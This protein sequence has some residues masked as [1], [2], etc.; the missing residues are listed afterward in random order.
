MQK[1]LIIGT[2][3]LRNYGCEAIVQGTYAILKHTLADAKVYVASDDKQY[4]AS[5]LPH[6]IR[7]V[8]YKQRFTLYRLWKGLLRRFFHYGTGSPVRMDVHVGKRF[9][10]V[11]SCGGDNYCEAPD[12]SLYNILLDL[13]A[14][15]EN[16]VKAHRKFV[17]WGASVGPFKKDNELSV[18]DNLQQSNLICVREKLSYDYLRPLG[19]GSKLNLTA[20]PAFLMEPDS[21]VKIEKNDGVQYI[22]L[23]ISRLSIGHAIKKAKEQE[24]F[25]NK[26]FNQL[27]A[28]LNRHPDW[29]FVCLPHVVIDNDAN[30]NDYVFMQKYFSATKHKSR[31]S[32]L[33]PDLGARK[34]K[35]CVCQMDLLVAARM[36]C[37]VAGI[38][39]STPTL[40]V[41]YSNKGRGMAEYAYGHHNYDMP[42]EGLVTDEFEKLVANMLAKKEQIR[43]GLENQQARFRNDALKAGELLRT[44][45]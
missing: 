28:I 30:Q 44:I 39:T 1:I 10:V 9:D 21:S 31:V 11:L 20:D 37:C 34:T 7:L 2:G 33:P 32:I 8:S 22:G 16:A 45:V 5:V 13:M 25:I 3:S 26:L 12:G 36:H 23:N 40:F 38:T 4:D 14:I 24:E 18:I 17:L 42:V 15:G 35:G 6:D 41:T 29:H 19:L 27:D 43:L